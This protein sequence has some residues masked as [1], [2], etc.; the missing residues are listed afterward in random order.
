MTVGVRRR[1]IVTAAI[2]VATVLIAGGTAF[3]AR[4]ISTDRTDA[5]EHPLSRLSTVEIIRGKLR[6]QTRLPGTLL[7]DQARDI[8]AGIAG[9]VTQL[10]PPGAQIAAGGILY[11][12]DTRPV[13][14]LTGTQ[15]AWRTFAP[16]MTAGSDIQ[17]LESNLRSLGLFHAVADAKF[18]SATA[19]AITAWQKSLGQPSSGTLERGNILF[20]VGDVR[21][22]AVTTT[23]GADV[24]V[25]S[26]LL[27]L[28]SNQKVVQS[29]LP[30]AA[31]RL[32]AVGSAVSI[33]L[34]DGSTAAGKV[35]GAS[36]AVER[37][38]PNSTVTVVPVLIAID[39]Q[40]A[41]SDF[42]RATV[43]VGYTSAQRDDVLSVP[44][45]ALVALDDIRF[46]VEIV[47]ADGTTRRIPVT[48]GLF[49]AGR[50]EIS[51]A[52]VAPGVDVV[53]PRR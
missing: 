39:D 28:S 17:Q 18:S 19:A 40:N 15:P 45:E 34:P 24:A 51:G 47:R 3:A 4:A 52:G 1:T 23:L 13:V 22:A 49:A 25:G 7:F 43:T 33:S 12:V 50:V 42:Q 5:A 35:A 10:P 48:T 26:P 6:E 11:S 21:V 41:V 16:G 53:V 46:G 29:D 32:A 38:T 9:V 14:L 30:V 20:A 44:V 27:S 37:V 36:A 2:V 8:P 31:Q